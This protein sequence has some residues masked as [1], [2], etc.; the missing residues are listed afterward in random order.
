MLILKGIYSFFTVLV[1]RCFNRDALTITHCH[2]FQN[3]AFQHS[4][5]L[6]LSTTFS[7]PMIDG[8]TYV[9]SC[10]DILLTIINSCEHYYFVLK[11]IPIWNILKMNKIMSHYE[12]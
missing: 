1:K 3:Q 11:S 2:I 6:Y 7:L 9:K 8:T 10:L 4:S 12:L 5:I